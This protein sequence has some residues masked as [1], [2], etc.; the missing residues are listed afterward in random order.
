[1]NLVVEVK[2]KSDRLA[3]QGAELQQC[4]NLALKKPAFSSFLITFVFAPLLV[5]VVVG[6]VSAPTGSTMQRIF[7]VAFPGLRLLPFF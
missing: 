2:Q 1:M 5:G 7:R 4:L 6:I 3:L